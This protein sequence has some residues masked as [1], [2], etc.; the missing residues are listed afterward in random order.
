MIKTEKLEWCGVRKDCSVILKILKLG[1]P[2]EIS[3]SRLHKNKED[4]LLMAY[5]L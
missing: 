2:S 1:P 4:T 3:S 5:T